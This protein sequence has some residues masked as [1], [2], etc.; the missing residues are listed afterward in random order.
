MKKKWWVIGLLALFISLFFDELIVK[1]IESSRVF[2]LNEFITGF[3]IWTN[4]FFSLI[5][6]GLIL[7]YYK[8]KLILGYLIGFGVVGA[9]A[10]LLKIAIRRA[11]P[12]ETLNIVS[13]IPDK[14]GFSFPS[15][16]AIFAFFCLGFIWKDFERFRYVWLIIAILIAFSRL[17][18]GVH[19][20]SDLIASLIIGLFVGNLFRKKNIF[21]G[22]NFFK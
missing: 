9:I 1:Y 16:H 7:L 21:K 15:G 12:F 13:L 10:Y 11:R 17:Y 20:L 4:G 6:I 22:L 18:V 19:Y 14:A 3:S 5:V 8:R 2:G